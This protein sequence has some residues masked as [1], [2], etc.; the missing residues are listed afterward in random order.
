MTP[1]GRH[2]EESAPGAG[3]PVEPLALLILVTA[4]DEET[5]RRLARGLVGERLAACVNLVPGLRSI[6][7][8]D[9]GIEEAAEWLLLVKSTS[10]RYDVVE[11]WIRQHHPYDVPECVAI[12]IVEG[13]APYLEWLRSAAGPL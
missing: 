2:P 5:A 4:P 11:S 12:P 6:Y 8:W 1:P 7:R 10:A 3:A 13:S 9:E